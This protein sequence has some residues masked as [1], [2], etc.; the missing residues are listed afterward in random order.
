MKEKYEEV[1]EKDKDGN[2]I[3]EQHVD[4]FQ[5]ESQY[6]KGKLVRQL[7]KYGNGIIEVDHYAYSKED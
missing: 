5:E 6:Y 4:G 2:I 3:F 1:L 7:T